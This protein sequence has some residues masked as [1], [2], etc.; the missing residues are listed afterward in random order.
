MSWSC[1]FMF[2][3]VFCFLSGQWMGNW[4]LAFSLWGTLK[5]TRNS[6]S[7]TSL[8]DLGKYQWI[9]NTKKMPHFNYY[10]IRNAYCTDLAYMFNYVIIMFTKFW[11][12]KK[13]LVWTHLLSLIGCSDVAQKCYCGSANCRGYLGQTKQTPATLK[14]VTLDRELGSPRSPSSSRRR[15]R[16]RIQSDADSAVS[17]GQST[18]FSFITSYPR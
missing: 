1:I 3:C 5:S 10:L 17:H 12:M 2:K 9:R 18:N 16:Q 13:N 6:L 4:G 7:T 14:V 8:R 15:P 11:A